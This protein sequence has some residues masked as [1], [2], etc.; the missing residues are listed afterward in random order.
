[1]CVYIY[2]HINIYTC[3]CMYIYIDITASGGVEEK[4][5]QVMSNIWPIFLISNIY[6]KYF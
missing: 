2:I 6:V 3:M 5:T 1:M 4:A